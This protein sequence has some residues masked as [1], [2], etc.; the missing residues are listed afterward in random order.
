MN[1]ICFTDEQKKLF[2][3]LSDWGLASMSE[4][5]K[6][7][8][9]NSN[10]YSSLS[11][12]ERFAELIQAYDDTLT[13]QKTETL[14]KRS[15]LKSKQSFNEITVSNERGFTSDMAKWISS[16]SWTHPGRISNITVLGASG[17]GKTTLLCGIGHHC[18][19]HG[20]SVRYYKAGQLLRDLLD[21]SIHKIRILKSNIRHSQIIIIDDLGMN[22]AS[23]E[24]SNALYDLLD[25]R[26]NELPVIVGSQ[27]NEEGLRACFT[28]KAQTDGILRRLFQNSINI[29][30]KGDPEEVE[31][32]KHGVALQEEHS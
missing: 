25:E 8:I 7:Q 21:S 18:I 13:A 22:K 6:I 24:A 1:T 29:I 20:L 16:L 11:F 3:K 28:G 26:V 30:L 5:L 23:D 19:S 9:E 27:V 32:K 10:I 2:Y 15:K 4:A 14:L 31:I 17:T 12:E